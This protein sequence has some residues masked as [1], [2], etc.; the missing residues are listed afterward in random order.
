MSLRKELVE[1]C[2]KVYARGFVSAYDGN[3][4]ARIDDRRILITPSGKCKGEIEEND[5]LEIDYNGN[6][7]DGNGKVS[8]EVKIHLVSYGKREDV[9]AVVHCHP[10]YATAFAAIGE[11]LMRPVFPE[12][13]LSLGK[14]PLCRY[15]TPSTDQLSDS[16]LPF[17]DYCWALLLENHGA[18]TFGKCIK[19]AFFRMEKLEW[20]AH[21]ISVARTI[22]REKVISNQKLKE[23]YSISEKVYGI[24][25]DKRNRF[26][27]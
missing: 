14:V 18:V 10:V 21:T 2:H 16:I 7:I 23:L 17:V 19:G 11:G 4:S 3:L 1:I 27:Y 25:I 15:G 20:A 12:V 24:K 26:D 6:L 22:G 9:Q 8:T 5:L 13:V